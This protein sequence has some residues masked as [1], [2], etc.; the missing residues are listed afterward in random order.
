MSGL[1]NFPGG[2]SSMG[3]PLNSGR[4]FG[5]TYFVNQT[6][7]SD[8]NRGLNTTR[9]FKTFTKALATVSDFDTIQLSGGDYTGNY[10]TPANADAAFVTVR[11][12]KIGD[13]GLCT[14]MAATTAS[15]PII[16][17]KSR[18][19]TFTDIEFDCP[20]GAGAI[21][22]NKSNDGTTDRPDFMHV[23]N[24]IF[25]TGK[26]G[27]VVDGG[28]T[29]AVIRKCQ[30]NQLTTTGAFAIYVDNTAH[31]IP[32]FWVVEDCIFATS[33]NHI[34]KANASHGFS[35]STFKGNV[36]QAFGVAT[37]VTVMMDIRAGGGGGNM[38]TRCYFDIAKGSV[39]AATSIIGNSTDYMAGCWAADGPIEV[40]MNS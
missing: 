7:G 36:H 21:N 6:T 20:T 38:V 8:Q 4:P 40:E 17:L 32:A 13:Y 26:Y 22:M 5:T 25:T 33:L 34:G 28:A 24:C 10:T 39:A 2:I 37:N 16:D 18:G 15:S 30:F 23:E 3:V 9:P 27:I 31:Q 12:F 1:T 19:W 11:G 14:W 35:E 29:Y